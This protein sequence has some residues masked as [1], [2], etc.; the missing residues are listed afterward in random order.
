MIMDFEK[1]VQKFLK[2][3][4]CIITLRDLAG[5]ICPDHDLLDGRYPP[6]VYTASSRLQKMGWMVSI[7]QG[8]FFLDPERGEGMKREIATLYDT[9]YWQ[10]ARAII[11]DECG[12]EY[13]IGGNKPLEL[14]MR[15]LSTPPVLVVFTRSTKKDISL[16]NGYKISF[17]TIAR[18]DERTPGKTGSKNKN[19]YPSLKKLSHLIEIDGVKLRIVD[20]ELALLEAL[21]ERVTGELGD[22]LVER[23]LKRPHTIDESI[24]SE[25]ASLRYIQALNRLRIIA[26]KLKKTELYHHTITLIYQYG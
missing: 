17:R 8:L 6:A 14:Y 26:K 2:R 10:M 22:H 20:R 13:V 23:Y 1:N 12:A 5:E 21:I 7:K 11:R 19:L 15:D 9:Y 4:Q 16:G 24:L 3:G 18:P 25:A